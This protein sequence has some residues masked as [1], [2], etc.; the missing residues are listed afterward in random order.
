MLE[1]RLAAY[2][3][4]M[5][6][7]KSGAFLHSAELS[8]FATE[9]A[10]GVCR[11]LNLLDYAVKKSVKKFPKPN[12]LTLLE[13]GL[14][15]I[16]FMDGVKEHAAVH[17]SA[18]LARKLK[19]GEGAVA[20]VNGVLRSL[21]RNG[22]PELP[23]AKLAR[24]S[25]EFSVPEFLLKRWAKELG[26]EAAIEFAA[27]HV[28]RPTWW[29]RA[30]LRAVTPE[31]LASSLKLPLE[32]FGERYLKVPPEASL[33]NLLE[34]E[35][36][37]AGK[38]SVQN[39]AAGEV[40]KLLDLHDCLSVW[41]ACAAPGGKASLMA[42]AFPEAKILASD[43]SAPRL[44]L[45]K[46]QF[47]K[48]GFGNVK[49]A[50]IDAA[51]EVPGDLFDRILLDVPCSNLGVL[52]KRPEAVYRASEET[53]AAL[54]LL[55]FTILGNASRALK[56]GGLLVYATCSPEP[57]ETLQVVKKFLA[58][59]PE[60]SAASAPLYTGRGTSGLDKFFAQALKKL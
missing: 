7:K 16:F 51:H 11:R 38:F 33:K 20:F 49:I 27:R 44:E 3:A 15:Q 59:H 12:V 13:M 58:A 41:D 56:P 48:S 35:E 43:V 18:E 30:N 23:K 46:K 54:S 5:K 19:L 28:E 26:E 37:L 8:P 50:L 45:M 17:T 40:L 14:Y 60:F 4:L 25:V 1:E 6:F 55:Q 39:P 9:L 42:E 29:L 21:M 52:D 53:F 2:N 22:L 10:V 36:F 32:V 34:S 24:A 57:A 31:A 47:E